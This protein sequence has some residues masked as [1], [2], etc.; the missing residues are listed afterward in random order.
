[1]SRTT[2]QFTKYLG[3]AHI[4]NHFVGNA[5]PQCT[6]FWLLSVPNSELSARILAKGIFKEIST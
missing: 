5:C 3:A 2:F 4:H 1:M 6:H